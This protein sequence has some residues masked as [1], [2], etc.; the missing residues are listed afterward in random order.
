MTNHW[1]DI[2]NSDVILIMGSNAA[3]N[4][5][6]AFRY[7]L[8]AQEKGAVLISVDPRF[9]KT[10]SKADIY[11]SLRSGSDIPFIGGMINYILEKR[12]FHED[13]VRLYTNAT[14]I[15]NDQFKMPGELNGIFSGYDSEKRKY[16]KKSW[17]FSKDIDGVV[18][19]DKTM[20]NPNVFYSFLKNTIH[21]MTLPLFQT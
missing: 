21:A 1:I 10:S 18:L 7:I 12:L 17:A 16:N 11:A 20:S 14:F 5:P 19:K 4:H 2:K 6:V 9:T 3:E 13:Y 8:K 15:L